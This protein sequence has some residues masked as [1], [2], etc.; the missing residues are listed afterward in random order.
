MDYSVVTQLVT[1]LGFPIVMCGLMAYYVKYMGDK[2]SVERQ[3]TSARH[4]EEIAKITDALNNN[5]IA[6]TRLCEKMDNMEDHKN[7]D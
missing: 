1:S 7:E 4:Q 3:E 5:T 2:F 6:L